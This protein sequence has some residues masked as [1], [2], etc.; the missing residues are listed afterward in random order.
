EGP[1]GAAMLV[2]QPEK[3]TY[4]VGEEISVQLPVSRA[5]RGLVTVESR[6][7][8]LH[9]EWIDGQGPETRYTFPATAEMAPNVYVHVTYLQPHMQT[10]NDL[11]IRTYG[12]VPVTVE[13]PETRLEPVVE[14]AAGYRPGETVSID[15]SEATGDA[16]TYTVAMVDEGLLGIT[17]YAAPDPWDHFY[18]RLA[19]S[20]T[21]WDL[22]D[23]VASAYTG[24]L[25]TLLAVGG[26][27]EGEDGGRRDANRFEPVVEFIPPTVLAAG[28]TNTHEITIPQYFGAVRVMVVAS[29]DRAFGAAEV[30]VPVRQEVMVL[31]TLPRV[32]GVN[33]DLRAPVTVF[34]I[35][36][37]A[38]LV[39]VE[40]ETEGPIGAEGRSRDF[41]RFGAPG[42]QVYRFSLKT[43]DEAG[44]AVV[45]FIARG[46]GT[47]A[48]DEIEIDVRVPGTRATEVIPVTLRS[49]E[50]RTIN[51]PLDGVAGTNRATLEVSRIPPIDLS[52]RLDYLIAYPHGCIEQTTSA[53]F[54]QLF[55]DR[56]ANLSRSERERTQENVAKGI[57]RI[58][59][60]QTPSGGFS[61]WPG[62]TGAHEWSTTYAGHFLLEADRRGY[63]LPAGLL[64][65]W[66]EYQSERANAWYGA[67]ADS[68][69]N[70]AY[71][72]YTLAL[73]R[74]PAYAAMN[75][76]REVE[77]LPAVARWRLAGAYALA[78]NASTAMNVIRGA[79]VA[80]V[81][82]GEPGDTYGSGVR[83]QAMILETLVQ[84]GDSRS[85]ALARELS[86][87]LT[88]DR[89]LSTQTSAYALLA[90]TKY[91]A[92]DSGLS[93]EIDLLWS[94][95]G[96]ESMR[97]VSD[98][99]VVT[100]EMPV[101]E[102]GE[103]RLVLE[104]RT[105]GRL[106]PRLIVEGLPQPGSERATSN[107]LRLAVGYYVDGRS[108]DIDRL[109]AGEDVEIRIRV[110]NAS[111]NRALEELVLNHLLPAGWE[112]QND[113]LVGSASSG[114][115]DFR[116]IRDDRVYTYFDLPAGRTVTFSTFATTAYEGRY[117]LPMVSVEAMYEPEI[118]ALVPGRWIEVG[119]AAAPGDGR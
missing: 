52:R 39:S 35:D 102:P 1:G 41:L 117:Y 103:S 114:N 82:Y 99:P 11:P 61:Y 116:D 4:T 46:A 104:N 17:G 22:Y 30:E 33:E 108:A 105:G 47:I 60:F 80:V 32:L 27:G 7:R 43:S 65:S 15:V 89:P 106:F 119:D 34:A 87:T 26:G 53:V 28:A 58:A 5:G 85:S 109:P 21:S 74:E 78:G 86:E 95:D 77:D 111:R 51:V 115:F 50:R 66:V 38:G 72:L 25:D 70:Q 18:Q 44:R 83:D 42:E 10:A 91:A 3:P 24:R 98:S 71:R 8:I 48:V 96:G 31:G 67:D 12:V 110:T 64:S 63:A 79:N 76:L 112:I 29:S 62:E 49:N 13:D 92:G 36:P 2:L 19:S 16:M 57:E 84:L 69:L 73:A 59:S 97:L 107:G 68:V 101:D 88:S 93:E 94:W 55:L 90:M 9:A 20:I 113:R 54:P 40:V 75:R 81:E 6:G 45:R 14:T 56:L 100:L 118:T 37:S 23:F